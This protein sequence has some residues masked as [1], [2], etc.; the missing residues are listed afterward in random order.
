MIIKV[1]PRYHIQDCTRDRLILESIPPHSYRWSCQVLL[2]HRP[3]VLLHPS[4][5]SEH[6]RET[7]GSCT[8]VHTSYRYSAVDDSE[9][10]YQL[11]TSWGGNPVYS[12]LV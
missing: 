9:L 1:G 4:H 11:H 10:S 2:S 3:H 7:E 6:R 12:R 5:N 8:D